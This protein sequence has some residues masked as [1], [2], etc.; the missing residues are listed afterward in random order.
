MA[1]VTA[2]DCIDAMTNRFRLVM[3]SAQRGRE[4]ASGVEPTVERDRLIKNEKNAV[5]AL[6]EI[7]QGNL[8]VEA[9]ED[10]IVRNHRRFSPIEAAAEEDTEGEVASPS[11]ER[12]AERVPSVSGAEGGEGSENDGDGAGAPAEGLPDEGLPEVHPEVHAETVF[13]AAAAEAIDK[14]ASDTDDETASA[15][16]S[17]TNDETASASASDTDDKTASAIS[18]STKTRDK[19]RSPYR[20]TNRAIRACAH[21]SVPRPKITSYFPPQLSSL[22]NSF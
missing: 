19:K 10:S 13:K 5:I 4:L 22:Q 9:L 1:R 15:S 7:T 2:E 8:D 6:R 3:C 20:S 18:P 14:T 11:A 21:K 16:A 17:D 12:A